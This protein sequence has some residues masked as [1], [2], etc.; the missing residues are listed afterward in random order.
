MS[1]PDRLTQDEEPLTSDE[2]WTKEA[3]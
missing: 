2:L 3:P 1:H